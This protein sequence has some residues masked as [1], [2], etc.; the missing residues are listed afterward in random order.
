MHHLKMQ[1]I[2]YLSMTLPKEKVSSYTKF[3]NGEPS[4]IGKLREIY[5]LFR[6]KKINKTILMKLIKDC[7]A[8][9]E[10][11]W[12]WKD[13]QA[14]STKAKIDQQIFSGKETND[15]KFLI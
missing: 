6:G 2:V 1:L 11:N 4:H 5:F 15:E 8:T 13:Y 10:L 3:A 9:W 14:F 7:V 12:Q